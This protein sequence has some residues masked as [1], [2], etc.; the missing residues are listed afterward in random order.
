MRILFVITLVQSVNLVIFAWF[1]S[2]AWIRILALR[3]QLTPCT[4]AGR[5]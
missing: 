2:V 5:I 1:N 3:Q 4:S